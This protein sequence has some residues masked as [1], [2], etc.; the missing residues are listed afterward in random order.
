[1]TVTH[2][3]EN[4]RRAPRAAL[5]LLAVCCL[6][7]RFPLGGLSQDRA[8]EYPVKLAFLYNFTKFIEWS[9]A[10]YRDPQAPMVICIV[11]RDPFDP[12]LEDALRRRKAGAHPVNVRT[13]N[14]GGPLSGC[15]IVFVPVS[16]KEQALRI[17]RG[18][19]G[20]SILT[21]GETEGFAMYSGIINLTVEKNK[22]RL[23]VNLPAAQR[24]GLK[25]S[26][27]LLNVA[28]IVK[29]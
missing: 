18:L 9:A 4:S 12:G 15:H 3:S 8:V 24:A 23:E 2:L 7:L 6:L 27:N 29:E 14:P 17:V 19:R 26:S 21:V 16:E 22:V 13:L 1:M 11:G 5:C 20:S 28:K 25:I 10:S